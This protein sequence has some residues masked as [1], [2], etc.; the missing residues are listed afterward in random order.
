MTIY[1]YKITNNTIV[2]VDCG[3]ITM[4]DMDVDNFI[5]HGN[6]I[7]GHDY[8]EPISFYHTGT[9]KNVI[10]SNNIFRDK[11]HATGVILRPVSSNITIHNNLFD[12]LS[13]GIDI[14]NSANFL[15]INNNIFRASNNN[16]H[17]LIATPSPSLPNSS[18]INFE[19][20]DNIATNFTK[21]AIVLR[22]CSY[23]KIQGN[24]LFGLNSKA[25]FISNASHITCSNNIGYKHND[26]PA[27]SVWLYELRDACSHITILE[28]EN[29]SVV[30]TGIYLANLTSELLNT[31]IKT[32]LSITGNFNSTY[33]GSNTNHLIQ[34]DFLFVNTVPELPYNYKFTRKININLLSNN[35]LSR[36]TIYNKINFE[37][38]ELF[39]YPRNGAKLTLTTDSTNDFGIIWK[40]DRDITVPTKLSVV[41]LD[42]HLYEI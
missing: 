41:Y 40:N 38:Y 20:N 2:N 6:L 11:P 12:N 36:L 24:V 32:N 21:D 37:V 33:V 42:N 22:G 29:N 27:N 7:K 3:I 15:S 18:I 39:V 14:Q 35:S 19:I 30:D 5:I 9:V 31:K 1:N 4:G 23:G 16:Y 13:L 28:E 8:S 10:I 25:I 17:G 34:K 26:A